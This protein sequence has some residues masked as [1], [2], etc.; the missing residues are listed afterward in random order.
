MCPA[1][2]FAGE[3]AG[4]GGWKA[5]SHEGTVAGMTAVQDAEPGDGSAAH[6]LRAAQKR[7]RQARS[8]ARILSDVF[9]IRPS[10]TDWL[11]P[12]T[13]VCRCEEVAYGEVQDAVLHHHAADAKTIKSLTRCGMGLC[14]GRMCGFA[15]SQITSQLSG[16]LADFAGDYA[17]RPIARPTTLGEMATQSEP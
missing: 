13:V 3:I 11:T 6:R 10:W 15:V 5:A 2:D 12:E 9:A 8:F 1:C 4:I 7:A 14:Q 17:T 16:A